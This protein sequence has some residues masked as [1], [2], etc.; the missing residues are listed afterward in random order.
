MAPGGPAESGVFDEADAELS[1]PR[2]GLRLVAPGGALLAGVQQFEVRV[3]RAAGVPGGG[4][5]R[6]RAFA[7]DG[8]PL[9]A[10]TGRPTWRSST[11]AGCLAPA[12]WPLKGLSPAAGPAGDRPSWW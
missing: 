12:G 3:D 8:K 4:A 10:R 2:P 6:A 5:D 1:A 9:L 11:W 7:L